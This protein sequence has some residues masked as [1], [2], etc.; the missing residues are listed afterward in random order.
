MN[1]RAFVSINRMRAGHTS[2]KASLNRFNI[3]STA[4]CECGDGLQTEEHIFWDCKR[5]ED[6]RATMMDILSE[7]SNKEYPKSVTDI[8]KICVLCRCHR[9]KLGKT[10]CLG[11]W[12]FRP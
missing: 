5:Y 11:S 1:R 7:N 3:V 4:E 12:D 9:A 6:Q 2:L 10:F 8:P